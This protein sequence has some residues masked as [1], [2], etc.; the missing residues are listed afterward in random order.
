MLANGDKLNCP[1]CFRDEEKHGH[2]P[3][4]MTLKACRNS[5]LFG[6]E[7]SDWISFWFFLRGENKTV[8]VD[9]ML[10][11]SD[12]K[13]PSTIQMLREMDIA[14]ERAL[15]EKREAEVELRRHGANTRYSSTD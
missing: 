14:F 4:C 2:K 9:V 12:A 13:D 15:G 5:H 11:M 3:E 6:A 8:P 1:Q 10:D 7:V